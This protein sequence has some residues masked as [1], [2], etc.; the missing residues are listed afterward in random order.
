MLIDRAATFR[1]RIIDHG[2]SKSTGGFPQWVAQLVA[3]EI[4][5]TDEE[6]WVDWTPYGDEYGGEI[7]AYNILFGGKGKAT[8]TCQQVK[9][10]TGWTGTSFADLT[11][12]DLTET[13]IQFRTEFSTW[14]GKQRLAVEWVDVYDAAPG[15]SVKKLDATELMGLDA[16]FSK[17]LKQSSKAKAPAKAGKVTKKGVQPTQAKGP[18][19]KKEPNPIEAPVEEKTVATAPPGPP[20]STASV[21]KDAKN[22]VSGSCTKDEAWKAVLDLKKKDI[23]DEALANLWLGALKDVAPGIE[24]E[25]VSGEQW[26][27]VRSKVLDQ[28]SAI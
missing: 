26:W 5:D 12:M 16:E 21:A 4:Y 7:T 28:V 25:D 8:L 23:G 15:R 17:Q 22:A 14:E 18:V 24:Q 9:L 11:K 27:V 13:Q 19:K 20:A 6:Q 3:M 10:A 1:G 2:V